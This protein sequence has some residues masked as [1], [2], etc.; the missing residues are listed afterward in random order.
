MPRIIYKYAVEYRLFVNIDMNLG[1]VLST[2]LLQMLSG[3]LEA[4]VY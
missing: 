2:E 1:G 3:E 4:T